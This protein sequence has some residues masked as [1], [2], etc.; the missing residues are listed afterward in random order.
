MVSIPANMP[1]GVELMPTPPRYD[2][3][4]YA[5]LLPIK[6]DREIEFKLRVLRVAERLPHDS[7]RDER[8]NQVAGD[9][10]RR[11]L[12]CP[13]RPFRLKESP[14]FLVP[15]ERV[16]LGDGHAFTGPANRKYH[17]E[18]TDETIRVT[19][20][21]M[22]LLRRELICDMLV[23]SF[24]DKFMALRD[25]FWRWH[26]TLFYKRREE[27]YDE[28]NRL[29]DAFRGIKFSVVWLDNLGLHLAVDA[30]TKYIGRH[31]LSDYLRSGDT[32]TIT[33]HLKMQ[34]EKDEKGSCFIR[35]NITVRHSCLF[36]GE[37]EKT[38]QEATFVDADGKERSVLEYYKNRFKIDLAPEDPMVY[39]KDSEHREA[40]P[41]PASR[42][43]PA[44]D[45]DQIK[46]M[47]QGLDI[48]RPPPPQLAPQKR[49]ETI[50]ELLED[51][52]RISFGDIRLNLILEPISWEQQYFIPPNL[53][54]G[55]GCVLRYGEISH[56]GHA[57]DPERLVTDWIKAK[58]P[59]LLQHGVFSRPALPH[60]YLWMPSKWQRTLRDK[61]AHFLGDELKRQ[62]KDK[63]LSLTPK[64]YQKTSELLDG[65]KQIYG[66]NA[67]SVIGLERDASQGVY[68]RIKQI[69]NVKTQ[70][71]SENTAVRIDEASFHRNLALAVLIDSGVKP[72][73]LEGEL[74]YHVYVGIDVLQNR[75]AFHFF[76]GPG[77]RN[78]LFLPGHSVSQARH[79]EAIKAK[80]I[81]KYLEQGLQDIYKETGEPIKSL[82][83]H[84][85]GRWWPSEQDGLERTLNKL[86]RS[87]IL[88][89][90]ISVA[91]VEIRKTHV[92]IRL[93]T[94][95]LY[96][97]NA[98]FA[99]PIPGVY[100]VLNRSQM[101]MVSTWN[102]IRPDSENGR[103]SGVILVNV[104]YS[105]PGH[106][107]DE[108]GKDVYD[109]T[110]LNWTAPG[111]EINVP[112]TIRWADHRLRETLLKTAEAEEDDLDLE[113]EDWPAEED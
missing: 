27:N 1:K 26:W 69:P 106:D 23:R 36:A 107:I 97:D 52:K 19:L 41:A 8:L 29:V 102:P 3:R 81:L 35:D 15:E 55:R 77:A 68:S 61:V 95:K 103:T 111:I 10:W 7:K 40:I 6:L 105:T 32:K 110:Q 42:L 109:L 91:V 84:R 89:E 94:R 56:P 25:K 31:S 57:Y 70:C 78:M 88:Q 83:I 100:R 62:C 46:K 75:A 14:S 38:V 93:L 39:V 37:S 22:D 17:L 18:L 67:L 12:K 2:A 87:G 28:K 16:S 21:E 71:F 54:F 51:L 59:A 98:F 43:F 65:L 64:L 85:D 24:S 96:K 86:K 44:F 63:N 82:T 73:V 50:L 47:H 74:N 90:D 99:N 53:Q 58:M 33:P 20:N 76:W 80:H 4:I 9:L 101:V 30:R 60:F 45:T 72:W 34:R 11:V 5:T 48:Q 79:Q 113:E 104:V 49:V 13:V 66:Q 112:V 92:P 108:I